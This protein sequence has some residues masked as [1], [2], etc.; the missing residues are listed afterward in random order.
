M[1]K[2]EVRKQTLVNFKD[3]DIELIHPEQTIIELN[4]RKSDIGKICFTKRQAALRGKD[5]MVVLSSF[6]PTRLNIAS[7]LADDFLAENNFNTALTKL[8]DRIRF[9]DF[10][11]EH[12]NRSI[13]FTDDQSLVFAYK[14]YSLYLNARVSL[15]AIIKEKHGDKEK[16]S[17]RYAAVLQSAARNVISFATN[18]KN[19]QIKLSSHILLK[20]TH[21]DRAAIQ[22]TL[23]RTHDDVEYQFQCLRSFL[24]MAC[25]V[26]IENKPLPYPFKRLS[27]LNG[28]FHPAFITN[29]EPWL[30]S[31]LIA[32]DSIMDYATWSANIRKYNA[33]LTELQIKRKSSTTMYKT[34][35]TDTY[36]TSL[37]K[38][39]TVRKRLANHAMR[40]AAGL[41]AMATGTNSSSVSNIEVNT[42]KFSQTTK[43]WRTSGTKLRAKGR[44]I[45][46]EF[47]A[48]FVP[49]MQQ[50]LDLRQYILHG[51]GADSKWI[52][53][54]F[55]LTTGSEKLAKGAL[56]R[57]SPTRGC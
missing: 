55:I 30:T 32:R 56:A 57:N 48:K 14:Q 24:D 36:Q 46:P 44:T 27:Q 31:E 4:N 23:S 38:Y 8:N 45:Y 11:D 49:I 2:F 9:F 1:L 40:V 43:S 47:G 54:K 7:L 20:E 3:K 35:Y 15:G 17:P 10:I 26:L 50:I 37:D 6:D 19:S 33:G 18:L 12:L 25:D 34:S 21:K 53:V 16:I 28:Y 41:F 29:A 51:L 5:C 13:D 52:F 42:L 22:A 39:S